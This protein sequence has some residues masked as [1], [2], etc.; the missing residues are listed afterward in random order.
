[1]PNGQIIF[2][3]NNLYNSIGSI[4]GH[5]PKSVSVI[6]VITDTL[7]IHSISVKK[8]KKYGMATQAEWGKADSKRKHGAA[9]DRGYKFFVSCKLI[10]DSITC[11]QNLHRFAHSFQIT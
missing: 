6:L 2:L 8:K 11:T 9:S 4:L 7:M 3:S 5:Y 1:L 10:F